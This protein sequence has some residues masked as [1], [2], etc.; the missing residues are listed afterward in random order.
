MLRL[1][2]KERKRK[3]FEYKKEG[4]KF[5]K[6]LE[7]ILRDAGLRIEWSDFNKKGPDIIAYINDKKIIFQCKHSPKGNFYNSLEDEVDSYSAKIKRYNADRAVIALSGY[8]IKKIFE[9]K[10]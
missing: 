10:L 2:K 8:Q 6:K 5:H 1:F 7:K 9:T 3:D 4:N